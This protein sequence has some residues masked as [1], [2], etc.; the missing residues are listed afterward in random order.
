MVIIIFDWKSILS[1]NSNI[2][3]E[4]KDNLD[5]ELSRGQLILNGLESTISKLESFNKKVVLFMDVPTP[6]KTNT[7]IERFCDLA[8]SK[9]LTNCAIDLDVVK[10]ERRVAESISS[11]LKDRYPSLIVFDPVDSFCDDKLC[12]LVKDDH[13]YYRDMVH[14]SVDGSRL[15]A[16]DFVGYMLKNKM[17]N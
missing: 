17:W 7:T 14:L 10:L 16:V 11:K 8:V 5:V 1:E 2:I 4:G 9:S 13:I 15:L 12:Y 3:L 6:V